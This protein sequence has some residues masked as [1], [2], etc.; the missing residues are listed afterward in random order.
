MTKLAQGIAVLEAKKGASNSIFLDTEKTFSKPEKFTGFHEEFYPLSEG[1]NG[2][3][4]KV[5]TSSKEVE[6]TVIEQ[7]EFLQKHVGEVWNLV[8]SKEETN[9]SGNAKADLIVDGVNFGVYSATTFLALKSQLTQLRNLY[10]NIPLRDT[11]K[12]WMPDKNRKN[13]YKTSEDRRIRTAKKT[14]Y[15]TFPDSTGKFP[16]QI[17]EWNEDVPIGTIGKVHYSGAISAM[18]KGEL[19]SRIDQLISAVDDARVRANDC[20]FVKVELHNKLFDFIHKGLNS[21]SL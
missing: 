8:L 4:E 3:V 19:L 1:E 11:A 20:E 18:E 6:T 7:V 21:A 17:K 2:K 12:T 10:K 9:S 13:I 14:N 5:D 16:D 15:K